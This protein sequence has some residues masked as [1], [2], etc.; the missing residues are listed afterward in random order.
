MHRGCMRDFPPTVFGGLGSA[1][2]GSPVAVCQC[3]LTVR[4]RDGREPPHLG[5]CSRLDPRQSF[6][7]KLRR[8][9]V[10]DGLVVHSGIGRVHAVCW[11]L[12]LGP[13][14]LPSAA[15][16]ARF[17]SDARHFARRPEVR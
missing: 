8:P 7:V 9:P 1:A 12:A 2:V 14:E 16:A 5:A 4:S 13:G 6:L 10:V 11:G 17:G 3:L 15:A